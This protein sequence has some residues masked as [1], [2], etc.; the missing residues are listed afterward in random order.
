MTFSAKTEQITTIP[1]VADVTSASAASTSSIPRDTGSLGEQGARGERYGHNVALVRVYKKEHT[2]ENFPSIMHFG[3]GEDVPRYALHGLDRH[4]R[5]LVFLRTVLFVR[6]AGPIDQATLL[7]L[8]YASTNTN[9]LDFNRCCMTCGCFRTP[10]C[11]MLWCA[12]WHSFNN[13]TPVPAASRSGKAGLNQPRRRLWSVDRVN[14][15]PMLGLEDLRLGLVVGPF[16]L[17]A[18]PGCRTQHL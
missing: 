4:R 14:H 13:G 16:V 7:D 8:P 1:K 11:T 2:I 3:H 5:P 12:A 15:I 17:D 9:L 10:G 18:R 6:I